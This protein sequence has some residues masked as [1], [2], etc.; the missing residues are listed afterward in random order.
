MHS[1]TIQL[2][3]INLQFIS[4]I[5]YLL[6]IIYLLNIMQ[7]TFCYCDVT[8]SNCEAQNIARQK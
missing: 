5:F 3:V 2:Y 8:F 7:A 1:F 4:N 6:Y